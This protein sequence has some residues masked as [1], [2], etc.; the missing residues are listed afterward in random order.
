MATNLVYKLKR[1]IRPPLFRI[2]NRGKEAF[3]CPVCEYRGPFKDKGLRKHAKCPKCGAL[4]RTRLQ[5]LVIREVLGPLDT[6]NMKALHFAPEPCIQE[7]LEAKFGFY[8]TADLNRNDVDHRIDIQELPFADASFDFI[9]AS[10]IMEYPA[11]DLLAIRE[12]RRVLRPTGIA[13]LPVPLVHEKTVD[14]AVRDSVTRMMHEPGLDYFDRYKQC[15][16]RV[17]LYSTESFG[18][19]YQLYTY[20]DENI[21]GGRFKGSYPLKVEEGKY[22]DIVPVCYVAE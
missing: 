5:F 11:N 16:P 8:E 4:E 2:L 10:H 3:H 20:R 19:Q 9:F 17:V 14:L 15:F 12:V 6:V 1:I 21:L 13:V 18:E 22:M 7:Y